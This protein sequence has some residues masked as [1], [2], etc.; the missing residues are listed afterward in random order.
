MKIRQGFVSNSSSSSFIVVSPHKLN[1]EDDVKRALF[2]NGEIKFSQKIL[3]YSITP[4]WPDIYK[5]ILKQKRTNYNHILNILE[6][7]Y[8]YYI[9]Y[10]LP[11]K[12]KYITR[13]YSASLKEP[14][15]YSILNKNRLFNYILLAETLKRTLNDLSK[16][17]Y[18]DLKIYAL[19]LHYLPP[20]LLKKIDLIHSCIY[21]KKGKKIR[22]KFW[23]LRSKIHKIERQSAV[24]EYKRIK[25]KYKNQ[26]IYAFEFGSDVSSL[27]DFIEIFSQKIFKNL[28]CISI[29]N[30]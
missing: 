14:I 13:G 10:N 20:N 12:L 26:Y 15:T 4:A 7:R 21:T 8:Q 27:A 24:A 16:E 28:F 22:S 11:I 2:P 5:E 29:S 9:R 18:K 19:H 6:S 1:T 17:T 30:H 25:N 3:P 23:Q